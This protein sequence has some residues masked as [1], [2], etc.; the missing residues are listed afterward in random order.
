M[1]IRSGPAPVTGQGVN[2]YVCTID[3]ENLDEMIKKVET[4]GGKI[5]L[6][7]MDMGGI[8][9]LAYA[10][11]TEGNIFGMMQSAKPAPDNP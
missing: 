5:A 2:A 10:L 6:P 9:F 1:L 11:D 7:K 8:G 4:M 3:V